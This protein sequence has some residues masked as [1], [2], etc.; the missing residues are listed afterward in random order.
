MK[1]FG[2]KS[3]NDEDEEEE[4]D[5]EKIR[6]RKCRLNYKMTKKTVDWKVLR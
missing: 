5:E 4:E 1:K 2:K 3:K 6:E